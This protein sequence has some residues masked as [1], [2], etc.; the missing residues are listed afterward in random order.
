MNYK[1]IAVLCVGTVFLAAVLFLKPFRFLE[2]LFYD[3][4]FAFVKSS[5][6]C[7]SVVIVGI[8]AESIS[9]VGMWPWPRSAIARCIEKLQAYSPRVV[10]I[11]VLFPLKREDPQGSDSLRRALSKVNKLILPYRASFSINGDNATVAVVPPDVFKQ[12]FLLVTRKDLLDA[13]GIF[14]ANRID[15]S[16]GA[17]TAFAAQSGV[18]NVTTSR[19]DQKL[20]EIVHVIKAGDEFYPSFGLCAVAA[21]LGTTSDEFAIDGRPQVILGSRK[22]PLSSRAGS[23]L[24]HFRGRSGTVKTIPAIK[25]LNG[26]ADAAS[27]RDKIVFFGVIDPLAGADFFTTPVGAQF[28]GVEL[29]ATSAMDILQGTWIRE[30]PGTAAFINVFLAFLIFPGLALVFKVKRKVLTLVLGF[31][32]VLASIAAGFILFRL[33]HCFWSPAPHVYAW[34]FSLL[35]LAV[36]KGAPTLVETAA[37][38]FD[39][40]Y[41]SD[42]DSLPPPSEEDFLRELPPTETALHIANKLTAVIDDDRKKPGETFSGTS[43]DEHLYSRGAAPVPPIPAGATMLSPELASKFQELSGGRIVKFLGSGGMADVYLIWNPR[44]EIYRAVKVIKPGQPPTL[45]A[46]FE[47]EIRI[48]SKLQHPHIVQFFNVGEWYSLPYIE[49]EYVPG[50]AMDDVQKKCTVLSPQEAAII[51]VLVCKALEYAHKKVATIYGTTY[52]G[53]I[54]RDL[55]PANIMLSRSGRV[56]LTDF[57]IARPQDVS[58]HTMDSGIVVGTLPYLAPEQLSGKDITARVDIY[59][60]GATLY[61]FLSG[62]RAFPQTDVPALLSAK[63]IGQYKPLTASTIPKTLIAVIAKAMSQQS[64]DR[65]ESAV[66]MER[67]LV[68]VLRGIGVASG[69]TVLDGLVKRFNRDS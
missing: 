18:I 17:F 66:A 21:Y 50:A 53:V 68:A 22:L 35:Y 39:A 49:M 34:F 47:T 36:A 2:N 44:L 59:A 46:R 9:N 11:D 1:K 26:M 40:P 28:P 24:L 4:N 57:G 42:N 60:L 61:E 16:D 48:L 56:K 27:L 19:M 13:S 62:E 67:D 15:A 6:T 51:G 37:I 8:D 14:S 23:V 55:K 10:A 7:D 29:W 30:M 25:V 12:R 38:D 33:M 45:L 63:S 54:H 65:Y 32:T 52:K 43:V 58:L 69:Y 41:S 31:V 3:S 20:R 64:E 5:P